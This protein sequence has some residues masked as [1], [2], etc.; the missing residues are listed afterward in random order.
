MNTVE[1]ATRLMAEIDLY[2]ADPTHEA[3][4][5]S[6][7]ALVAALEETPSEKALQGM[8]DSELLTLAARAYFG[9]DGFEWN[10]CSGF[11]D[12]TPVD[13]RSYKR[14]NP[15][16]DD[17]DALRRAVKLQLQVTVYE[18]MTVDGAPYR[19]PKC[20]ERGQ[21]DPY[22]AAR[23]AIVKMAALVT[24]LDREARK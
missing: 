7:S 19:V 14:W 2:R 15:L 1:Q 5:A 12:Y 17:G 22:M 8:P 24:V 10:A 9:K 23:L 20:S 11:T 21:G 18:N 6:R 3:R 16:F 4:A 13:C